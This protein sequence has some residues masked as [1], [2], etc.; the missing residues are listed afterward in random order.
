M[1]RQDWPVAR[2]TGEQG[3][4][5]P[6][7]DQGQLRFRQEKE[8]SADETEGAQS[9]FIELFKKRQIGDLR[10]ERQPI[11]RKH[12]SERKSREDAELAQIVTA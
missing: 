12:V 10:V 2:P 6:E 4:H 3:P 8:C 7:T 5:D 1:L 9:H 11:V